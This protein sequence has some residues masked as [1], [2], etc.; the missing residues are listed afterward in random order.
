MLRS[1]LAEACVNDILAFC[2]FCPN[3][4]QLVP[5]LVMKAKYERV[6]EESYREINSYIC[7]DLPGPAM[8]A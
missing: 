3:L 1:E 5:G 8:T 7:L 4:L 2:L 6:Q